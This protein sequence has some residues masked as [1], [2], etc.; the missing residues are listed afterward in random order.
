M[1]YDAPAPSFTIS[2]VAPT[3]SL[4]ATVIVQGATT[5]YLQFGLQET[6][7]YTQCNV[8]YTAL[9]SLS[10]KGPTTITVADLSTCPA[11]PQWILIQVVSGGAGPVV[12]LVDS[13]SI[14]NSTPATSATFSTS[15]SVSPSMYTTNAVW[16]N[17]GAPQ[18]A[19]ETLTWYNN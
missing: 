12:L 6:T 5:G 18:T 1:V 4:T 10:G 9:S 8:G 3:S 17:T 2:T 7:G 11:T 16:F 15:S 19:N 14:S 13:L